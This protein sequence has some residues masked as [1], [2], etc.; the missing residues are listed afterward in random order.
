MT[1]WRVT[2]PPTPWWIIPEVYCCAAGHAELHV[3]AAPAQVRQV[4]RW[5]SLLRLWRIALVA[6]RSF[7]GRGLAVEVVDQLDDDLLSYQHPPL[8][9]YPTRPHGNPLDGQQQI[10]ALADNNENPIH[11]L[12]VAAVRAFRAE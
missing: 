3:R 10:P 1:V 5:P 4:R 2:D 7:V 11:A 6:S 12:L 8:R 9:S